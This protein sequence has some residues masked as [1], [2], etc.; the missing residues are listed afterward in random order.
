MNISAFLRG[1]V[2]GTVVIILVVASC[3]GSGANET[4]IV[5]FG[6]VHGDL[7]ATR[8]ALRLA[9]IGRAHV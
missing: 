5:A 9:E 1:R 3:A 2:W 4:R 8:S 6:D 7:R